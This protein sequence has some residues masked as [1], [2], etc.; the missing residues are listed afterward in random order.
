[1]EGWG[2]GRVCKDPQISMYDW[3]KTIYKRIR[4]G[5]DYKEE[6]CRGWSVKSSDGAKCLKVRGGVHE[7]RTYRGPFTSVIRASL[8]GNPEAVPSPE[9]IEFG[10]G[11][12][13]ISHCLD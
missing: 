8:T 13:A 4:Q 2:G 7:N 5:L 3:K 1:M 11:I 9:K 10:I 12:D 6:T